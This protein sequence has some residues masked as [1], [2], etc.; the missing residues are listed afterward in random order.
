MQHR[1]KGE[2]VRLDTVDRRILSLLQEDGSLS[3]NDLAERIGM[4]AP[5]CWRRVRRLKDEGILERQVWLVDAKSVGLSVTI[6]ASVKLA[7]HDREATTA[8]RDRIKALAEV[9]ECYILLGTPDA[10]LK[11]VVADIGYYEEFFYKRLS[12]IPG[13]REVTSS[14]VMSQ[15]KNTTAIPL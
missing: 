1:S 8:F 4:T 5:P 13:V 12:Q 10:L 7:T 15:V 6:Y 11:I 14:V 9:L 2:S 3:I